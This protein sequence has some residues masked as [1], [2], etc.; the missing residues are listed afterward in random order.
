MIFSAGA[1][2]ANRSN[3]KDRTDNWLQTSNSDTSSGDLR[4]TSNRPGGG[5][6]YDTQQTDEN[7]PSIPV[8]NTLWIVVILGA[9]YAG[10][11]YRHS[12][13][14]LRTACF[15]LLA[16]SFFACSEPEQGINGVFKV[17]FEQT[18]AVGNAGETCFVPITA[19]V[20]YIPMSENPAWCSIGEKTE[21]GFS[22]T[23]L[24]NTLAGER[25]FDVVVAAVGFDFYR[26]KITQAA[27]EPN[28]SIE[29]EERSKTFSQAGG[30]LTVLVSGNVEYTVESSQA[31]CVVSDITL[32]SFKITA[33][34][35]GITQRTASLLV[36]PVGFPAVTINVKQAGG[37]ILLN[38]WFT[39]GLLNN[40]TANGTAGL[41]STATDQYIVAGAPAGAYY[42][43]NNLLA[44]T[45]FEG[46]LT[47]KLSNVPDGNYTLSAQFAGRPGA[48]PAT[49]G[50]Y[51]IAI[52]K[53]G[54]EQQSAVTLPNGGWKL[55]SFSFNVTGGEVTVGIYAKAVGGDNSTMDFKVM[56]FTFQ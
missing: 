36:K 53:N 11:K 54:N 33:P 9:A 34:A 13:G 49:D 18:K 47:Q 16:S 1:L 22:F 32:E 38:G 48:S 2:F 30:D 56:G 42:V 26:I 5:S 37:E 8:G 43:K 35:N 4:S 14:K 50:V 41:Y 7:D 12:L 28:F 15:L 20:E 31:W 17:D 45:G 55:G 19:T 40:W 52:D 10:Y 6:G 25:K 44:M 29:I 24:P 39:G 27:G 46:R 23:V 21:E 51:L 3:I